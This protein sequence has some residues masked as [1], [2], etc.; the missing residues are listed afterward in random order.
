MSIQPTLIITWVAIMLASSRQVPPPDPA[1]QAQARI[2]AV[3]GVVTDPSGRPVAGAAVNYV[4]L[5][6]G[7]RGGTRTNAAGEFRYRFRIRGSPSSG[8]RLANTG[9]HRFE[10][11]AAG[12]TT[13]TSD[14]ISLVP[15]Q[16]HRMDVTL[17]PEGVG[18]ATDKPTPDEYRARA[19]ASVLETLQLRGVA[20]DDVSVEA[21]GEVEL[22]PAHGELHRLP[23][24]GVTG[25]SLPD[26]FAN[27][28]SRRAGRFEQTVLVAFAGGV[29]APELSY[30][31]SP[32]FLP[33]EEDEWRRM[34]AAL[35]PFYT[36]AVEAGRGPGRFDAFLPDDMRSVLR[37]DAPK[38]R[39]FLPPDGI[40]ALGQDDLR[41]FVALVFDV[42]VLSRWMELEGLT[43]D[44]AAMPRLNDPGSDLEGYL[45]R[46]DGAAGGMRGRLSQLGAFDPP[47][48][49]RTAPYMR[50]VLGE[51][52]L[53]REDPARDGI[54]HLGDGVPMYTVPLGGWSSAFYP[55]FAIVNGRLTLVAID[56]P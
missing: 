2:P 11:K 35:E 3:E 32:G 34:T 55:H 28:V 7:L 33:L 54:D 31:G 44:R 52:L 36:A 8:W 56:L 24:S 46:L 49:A 30:N 22:K 5:E 21:L 27:V 42:A 17:Q 9:P 45:S 41:R 37:H 38:M 12:F 48:F 4:H 50:R 39:L 47:H 20:T 16:T 13:W 51:G 14:V 26:A 15:G 19:M 23:S 6:T 10:V 1:L 29:A 53:V 18:D 25:S 40:D 43:I